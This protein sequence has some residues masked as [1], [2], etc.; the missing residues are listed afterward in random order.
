[1]D[2]HQLTYEYIQRL[3]HSSRSNNC[4]HW[5]RNN[6][7]SDSFLHVEK[8]LQII[9]GVITEIDIGGY[10]RAIFSRPPKPDSEKV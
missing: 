1:M 4:N 8:F 6:L 7:L 2:N 5:V 9:S 10:S 3:V